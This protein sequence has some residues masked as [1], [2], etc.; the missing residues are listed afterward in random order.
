MTNHK[1]GAGD[2][3]SPP[4][5]QITTVVALGPYQPRD[6]S[7]RFA[8]KVFVNEFTGCWI[9][10]GCTG[11]G[12]YGQFQAAD[13]SG[14][15]NC[16]QP[17]HRVAY[18]SF[19]GPIPEGLD[20]DHLC[21]RRNCVNPR[22]LE[23]VTRRENLM[24]GDTIPARKAAQTHCGKGHEFTLENTYMQKN[25]TR[26]CRICRRQLYREWAEQNRERR[27]ELDRNHYHTVKKYN[28]KGIS[29]GTDGV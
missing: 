14:A 11:E 5:L 25:G 29:H 27:R 4:Q 19:Y 28:R 1:E 3:K 26:N 18:E 17:V 12:G 2:N 15:P 10:R 7:F 23:P 20:L 13:L 22:H 24:R 8:E 9:W 6:V 16:V 21:S